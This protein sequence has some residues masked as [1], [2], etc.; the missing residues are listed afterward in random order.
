MAQPALSS[1][2]LQDKSFHK[3]ESLE[4]RPSVLASLVGILDPSLGVGDWIITWKIKAKCIQQGTDHPFSLSSF[5]PKVPWAKQI[6]HLLRNLNVVHCCGYCEKLSHSGWL[7][8]REM[9]SLMVLEARSPES[10]SLGWNR[11]VSRAVP[12]PDPLGEN[13]FPASSIFWWLRAFFGLWLHPSGLEGSIL[14]SLS[15]L[16]SHQLLLLSVCLK[17]PFPYNNPCDCIQG[18][19]GKCRIISP[20]QNP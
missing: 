8:T 14:K 3:C 1:S 7:K 9:Y 5:L 10:E 17:S 18:P 4:W 2:K 15:A 16:S 6:I 12:L 19:P 20:S 11:G 13:P